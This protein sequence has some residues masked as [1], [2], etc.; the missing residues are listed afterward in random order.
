[1]HVRLKSIALIAAMLCAGFANPSTS[2]ADGAGSGGVFVPI[3]YS[4]LMAT[5]AVGSAQPPLTPDEERSYQVL[6]T[7]GIPATGVAAVLVDVAV[8]SAT[9]V[10][11]GAFLW[12][13]GSSRPAYAQIRFGSSNVPRSNTVAVA[14]GADGKIKLGN[15]AG[16]SGFNI[17]IQGYFTAA[18]DSGAAPGGF[19]PVEPTRLVD[20]ETG[21]G[22]PVSPLAP[23][24]KLRV[25][26]AVDPVPA[27]AKAVFAN[28]EVSS[29]SVDGT[30]TIVPAGQSTSGVPFAINY[31]VGGRERTGQSIALSSSGE[32][33]VYNTGTGSVNLKIDVEGYFSGGTADGGG[34]HVSAPTS[35]LDTTTGTQLAAGEARSIDVGGRA[36]IP[37]YG[38][39]GAMLTVQAMNYSTTGGIVVRP[40]GGTAS[41]L[42]N[43]T[44]DA[45][46][47]A[48]NA[49]TSVVRPGDFGR[50][51][52]RNNSTG[53][54]DV[55]IRL[56]G[57]FDAPRAVSTADE[58]QFRLAAAAAGRSAPQIEQ[59][60]YEGPVYNDVI[61][62]F[63]SRASQGQAGQD[64]IDILTSMSLLSVIPDPSAPAEVTVTQ[65]EG[66]VSQDTAA[67]D[68]DPDAA[69]LFK[70]TSGTCAAGGTPHE[71]DYAVTHK[72][73]FRSTIY[74]WHHVVRYCMRSTAVGKWLNRYDYISDQDFVVY[75]RELYPNE[76]GGIGS[77]RAW[78]FKQRH[79]ELCV[80]KYGCYASLYPRSKLTVDQTGQFW[81]DKVS[82]S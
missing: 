12:P 13:S 18:G 52:V 73:L 3:T 43:V 31:S 44:F 77:D 28:I 45:S 26:L 76:Q 38:S 4:R 48:S 46:E 58:S 23:G 5:G 6:G 70:T 33:D 30:L 62:S 8:T 63:M 2:S 35:L 16:T 68:S 49:A 9:A 55:R 59:S 65:W 40:E 50:V 10:D 79:I 37:V 34:F 17:D 22:S 66:P 15:D 42:A 80:L 78:S 67:D 47:T 36:G 7:H 32:A 14:V 11:T 60:L 39:G 54:V 69:P 29:I 82:A 57:W 64:E 74:K 19:V 51:V 71:V 56:Q 21:L 53:P 72:S 20:T 24:E 41:T 27:D 61:R 1:M 25:K 81:T 75:V